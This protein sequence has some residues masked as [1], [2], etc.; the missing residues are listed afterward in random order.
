MR[1]GSSL[2]HVAGNPPAR[3]RCRGFLQQ[4]GGRAS[5][6]GIAPL[7]GVRQFLRGRHHVAHSRIADCSM[8][9]PDRLPDS[10]LSYTDS[11]LRCTV[12][13]RTE[14]RVKGQANRAQNRRSV[15]EH[16]ERICADMC[17]LIGR[18]ARRSGATFCAA[19]MAQI[20]CSGGPQLTLH[21]EGGRPVLARCG[22]PPSFSLTPPR[23]CKWAES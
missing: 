9:G 20:G 7:Q 4:L 19:T 13:S 2:N 12:R 18:C 3:V 11:A 14:R 10:A 8:A 5:R 22:L 6:H 16:H 21:A 1:H 17:V 23:P 15:F